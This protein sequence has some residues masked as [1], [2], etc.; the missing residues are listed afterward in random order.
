MPAFSEL[1]LCPELLKAVEE[2]GYTEPTPIQAQA[3]PLVLAGRDLMG[4]AQTGT[5]KTSGFVLPILQRLL[6]HANSSASPAR[7]PVRALILTPTR[8]LAVQVEET[9]AVLWVHEEVYDALDRF[10]VR[11]TA[12]KGEVRQRLLLN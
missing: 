1:G 11:G 9:L 2:Q 8:E 6:Q 12:A 5:G 7:H 4:A 3:I 10:I